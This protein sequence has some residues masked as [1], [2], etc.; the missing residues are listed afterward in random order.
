MA[1]DRSVLGPE[2]RGATAIFALRLESRT[3][4]GMPYVQG[5]DCEGKLHTPEKQGY[6]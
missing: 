5:M 1:M 6:R 2:V 3:I 4:Y